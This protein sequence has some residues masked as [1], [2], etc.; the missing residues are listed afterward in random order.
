M[1]LKRITRRGAAW[2]SALGSIGLGCAPLENA[3]L[4]SDLERGADAA[5][6][7]AGASSDGS[8]DGG[9]DAAAAVSPGCGAR[10]R[11]TTRASTAAA[12][13]RADATPDLRISGDLIASGT[14][15][16]DDLADLGCVCEVTR[17][18]Y[19]YDLDLVDLSGF[20]GLE[21]V[22]LLELSRLPH[23]DRL[24]GALALR[25]IGALVLVENGMLDD[26]SGL[27]G[28][29][30][31]G[32]LRVERNNL[33]DLSGL[34]EGLAVERLEVHHETRLESLAPL[35]LQPTT[36]ELSLSELRW[37][38]DISSLQG[39]AHIE[40]LSLTDLLVLDE[41]DVL[42]DVSTI[43][44]VSIHTSPYLSSEDTGWLREV[45]DHGRVTGVSW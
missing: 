27:E 41:I 36:S 4:A 6:E 42:R 13:C 26:L 11:N 32:Q 31:L 40:L 17:A 45:A 20:G 43:G 8:G 38:R 2:A 22:G 23:F 16:L 5:R 25:S 33:R 10:D 29:E 30:S 19:I 24:E 18:L 37:L 7:G 21:S 44:Y 35:A 34:P 15:R 14:E 3:D 9:G 12:M 28:L 39:A 1:T